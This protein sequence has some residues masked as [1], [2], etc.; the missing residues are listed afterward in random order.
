MNCKSIKIRFAGCLGV[1]SIHMFLL[2]FLLTLGPV[3]WQFA[4][5][6]GSISQLYVRWSCSSL[7]EL[8]SYQVELLMLAA[9]LR[10]HESVAVCLF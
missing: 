4:C 1:S 9:W 6:S 8:I 2:A 3:V 7:R 5:S 10:V